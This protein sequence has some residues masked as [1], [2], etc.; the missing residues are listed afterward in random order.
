MQQK[1]RNMSPEQKNAQREKRQD[2]QQEISPK[3]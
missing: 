1:R 3:Q 2:K